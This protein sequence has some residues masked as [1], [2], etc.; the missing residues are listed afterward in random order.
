MHAHQHID[1]YPKN[2][3]THTSVNTYTNKSM[4]DDWELGK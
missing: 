2:T 1:I 3:K 4:N